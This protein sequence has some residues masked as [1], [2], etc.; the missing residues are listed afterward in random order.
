[1]S[2]FLGPHGKATVILMTAHFESELP[3][4]KDLKKLLHIP[5]GRYYKSG[6]RNYASTNRLERLLGVLSEI[7]GEER[8]WQRYSSS[9]YLITVAEVHSNLFMTLKYS[10][11]VIDGFNLTDACMDELEQLMSA[12]NGNCSMKGD[13]SN[14]WA[15]LERNKER[16]I[17]LG[18]T[19]TTILNP[20]I[21]GLQQILQGYGDAEYLKATS[22]LKN[23]YDTYRWKVGTPSSR[24]SSDESVDA[25]ETA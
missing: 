9:D 10:A 13:V 24:A 20:D 16:A 1:M 22:D 19:D 7:K 8:D 3:K 14:M 25:T 15:T 6:G 2:A 23:W 18:I 21:P 12:Y 4:L 5:D 17:K 11:Q